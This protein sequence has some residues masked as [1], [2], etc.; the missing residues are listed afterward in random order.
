[1]DIGFGNYFI[2]LPTTAVGTGFLSGPGDEAW[3]EPQQGDRSEA[4]SW[5]LIF[6]DIV[7][8]NLRR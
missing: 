1:M 8:Q 7:Q 2:S 4:F 6:I 5:Y 3:C